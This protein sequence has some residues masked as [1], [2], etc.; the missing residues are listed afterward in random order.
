MI[1]VLDLCGVRD[2]AWHGVARSIKSRLLVAIVG[3]SMLVGRERRIVLLGINRRLV[4]VRRLLLAS[5]VRTVDPLLQIHLL[6]LT[7]SRLVLT[8]EG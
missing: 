2:L 1:M 3:A 8:I 5:A 4:V 6:G 7:R